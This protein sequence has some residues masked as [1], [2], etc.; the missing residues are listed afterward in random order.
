MYSQLDSSLQSLAN[1]AAL[2]LKEVKAIL[3]K[4]RVPLKRFRSIAGRVQHAARILPAAKA[5][6]TPMNN[7]LKGAPAFIGLPRNGEIRNALLDFASVI[8]DLASRPTHVNELVQ[9]SLDSTTD[10]H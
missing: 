7:A 1:R 2:L 10:N 3:K 5:F 8:R 4:R 9:K 6:F